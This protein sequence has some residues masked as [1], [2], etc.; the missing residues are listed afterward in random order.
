MHPVQ[1]QNSIDFSDMEVFERWFENRNPECFGRSYLQISDPFSLN[2][3][4]RHIE[5]LPG[6]KWI[7][8][9]EK[10][11]LNLALEGVS[12]NVLLETTL[13]CSPIIY[14]FILECDLWAVTKSA[15][16]IPPDAPLI[17]TILIRDS[18]ELKNACSILKFD[19]IENTYKMAKINHFKNSFF[20]LR[21][22]SIFE[23]CSDCTNLPC[24]IKYFFALSVSIQP[25]LSQK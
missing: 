8:C 15:K 24:E 3:N 2:W 13:I 6:Q 23:P 16:I 20:D 19:G 5:Y 11:R 12:P 17:K 7:S 1:I 9:G 14:P 4:N 18:D 21:C 10:L 25:L 22:C